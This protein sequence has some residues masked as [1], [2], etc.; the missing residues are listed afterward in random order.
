MTTP[1]AIE[2]FR[3]GVQV[4]ADGSAHDFSDAELAAA[5]AAYD[6]ALHQAPLVVGHPRDD[7]PAYG[8][9]SGLTYRDDGVLAATPDQVEDQF[10]ELV[11]A[12]RLKYVS[13]SFYRPGAATNPRPGAY[14]L[15]HVGFLGAQPPAVKGL[16]PA[17]FADAD[18]DTLT[19]SFE[20]PAMPDP[21][22][23]PDRTAEFA[24]REAAICERETAL[25]AREA[26]NE[27]ERQRLAGE[28]AAAHRRECAA[29]VEGLVTE[30][31]VLPRDSGPLVA[32]LASLPGEDSAAHADF[33][34][35][36][37][38]RGDGPTERTPAAY[39]RDLLARLPVQVDFSER[40]PREQG[41]TPANFTAP[42]GYQVD[43]DAARLHSRA[44]AYQNSHD[45]VSYLDAVRAVSKR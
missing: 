20:E 6:P 22:P 21:A 2:I 26:E 44:L 1:S 31:R 13:A 30:G 34:E 37:E 25:A 32:L 35:P 10:A 15:R 40:T 41:E 16:R 5:A 28:T 27:A 33:A 18:A 17:Q 14:Y 7:A 4:A 8:W 24:E 45:G 36:A 23:A 3:R 19:I 9:V 43:P 29:H 39:L 38:T 42:E 11:R 12:G